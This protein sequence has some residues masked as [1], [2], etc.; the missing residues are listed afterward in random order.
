LVL[1]R[2]DGV[3]AVASGEALS[4]ARSLGSDELA[5]GTGYGVDLDVV[6]EQTASPATPARDAGSLAGSVSFQQAGDPPVGSNGGFVVVRVYG[7]RDG[8]AA[9]LAQAVVPVG[10]GLP[11]FNFTGL[12]IG[13]RVLRAYQVAAAPASEDEDLSGSAIRSAAVRV[14][15][16][17]GGQAKDLLLR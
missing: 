17:T 3:T 2:A 4:I 12:P 13:P 10:V 7:P 1:L 5:G 16:T 9:T 6:L 11:G 8:A 15:L 14:V